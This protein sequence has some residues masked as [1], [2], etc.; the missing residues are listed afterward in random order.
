L[1]KC[2][3]EK[4]EPISVPDYSVNMGRLVPNTS[5]FD[6]IFW[7]DIITE[8]FIRMVRIVLTPFWTVWLYAVQIQGIPKYIIKFRVDLILAVLMEHVSGSERNVQGCH[9]VDKN[10]SW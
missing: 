1:T 5:S 9:S 3:E 2:G 6:T 4:E 10:V 8:Q 7:K